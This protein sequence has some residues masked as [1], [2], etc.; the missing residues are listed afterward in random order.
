MRKQR[1]RER[2]IFNLEVTRREREL[3]AK[4]KTLTNWENEINAKVKEFK[5]FEGSHQ[6][7]FRF[8]N[9]ECI[10]SHILALHRDAERSGTVRRK[11]FDQM[12]ADFAMREKEMS[13][14]IARLVAVN[15]RLKTENERLQK[16]EK[17]L[18]IENAKLNENIDNVIA[19][20]KRKEGATWREINR[21][22]EQATEPQQPQPAKRM[23]KKNRKEPAKR[24]SLN[25][26]SA[27]SMNSRD[28]VMEPTV[29]P[30]AG[31]IVESTEGQ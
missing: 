7:Y 30:P 28:S 26:S 14:K 13:D 17:N 31:A 11:E 23:A 2:E 27:S 5:K 15:Q 25:L 19:N 24:D 6:L 16:A 3:D 8:E 18:R 10:H 21:I 29:E 9:F 4:C 20:S 22:V 12:K 1:E